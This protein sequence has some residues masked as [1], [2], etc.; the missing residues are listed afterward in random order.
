MGKRGPQSIAA[1]IINNDNRDD[2]DQPLIESARR[3]QPLDELTDEQKIEWLTVVNRMPADWFPDETLALLAQY[4]RHVVSS[5]RISQK[6]DEFETGK[7]R[8]VVK[9]YDQLLRMREREGRA[10]SSLA[11]R[12]RISQHSSYDKTKQRG[13]VID[14]SD[15]WDF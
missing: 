3:P 2:D 9:S 5:R 10:L 13:K 7:K 12:M 11:T 6:I 8:M 14:E 1:V 15:P 4:C